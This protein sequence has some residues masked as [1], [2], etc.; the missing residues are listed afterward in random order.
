MTGT[1]LGQG[2]VVIRVVSGISSLHF[3]SNL[4]GSGFS[5]HASYTA[6]HALGV[7]VS[8]MALKVQDNSLL[9]RI[10]LYATKKVT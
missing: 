3:R 5:G 7:G 4:S 8:V 2:Q 1:V 10:S 6:Q 9:S